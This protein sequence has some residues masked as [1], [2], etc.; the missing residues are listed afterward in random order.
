MHHSE[1][2]T[3][4][5]AFGN[6]QSEICFCNILTFDRE[7]MQD[8]DELAGESPWPSTSSSGVGEFSSARLSREGDRPE[9][10]RK[11]AELA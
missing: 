9:F 10:R 3:V 1:Y 11:V 4:K 7:E 2:K 8:G 5:R 6:Q